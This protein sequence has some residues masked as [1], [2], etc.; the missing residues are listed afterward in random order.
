MAKG[1]LSPGDSSKR[2][3]N[4]PTQ[5]Q[6][7]TYN[8]YIV[9]IVTWVWYGGK[10]YGVVPYSNK[11]QAIAAAVF[12]ARGFVNWDTFP[13]YTGTKTYPHDDRNGNEQ[14]ML[15]PLFRATWEIEGGGSVEVSETT[16]EDNFTCGDKHFNAI[17]LLSRGSKI[18]SNGK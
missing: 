12:Y 17:E 6:L 16:I 18:K 11:S 2:K 4:S 1:N 9:Y 13:I 10:A 7:D 14:P 5:L 15:A 3:A 8:R